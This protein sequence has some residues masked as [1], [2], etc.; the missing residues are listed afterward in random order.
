MKDGYVST[1][2]GRRRYLRELHD[3]NYQVRESAKRAA[4]N[5]PVQG[6][7]ADLIK[8]AMNQVHQA[9]IDNK[10][11]TKMVLQI[12]DE[13]I[14]SVPKNEKEKAY[15]LIKD[16]MEHALDIDVPLLVDGGFGHDWYSAK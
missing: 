1:L 7:A 11:E 3:A 5:A 14:F 12:H 6:T 8:L 16:I 13:L 4:M 10:L 2:L 9:L 15:S